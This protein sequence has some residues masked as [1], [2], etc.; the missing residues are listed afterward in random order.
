[1]KYRTWIFLFTSNKIIMKNP[2]NK[3][4]IVTGAYYNPDGGYLAQ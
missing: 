3:A 2:E 4:A 1:M